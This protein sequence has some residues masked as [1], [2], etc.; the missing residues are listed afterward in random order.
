MLNVSSFD[1][2]KDFSKPNEFGLKKEKIIHGIWK[3]AWKNLKL[4]EKECNQDSKVKGNRLGECSGDS[5]RSLTQVRL[6]CRNVLKSSS[7]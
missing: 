4:K 2:G 1:A 5:T 6:N 3:M 7:V